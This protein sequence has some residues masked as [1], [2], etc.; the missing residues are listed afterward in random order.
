MQPQKVLMSRDGSDA[1]HRAMHAVPAFLPVEPHVGD[2][3]HIWTDNGEMVTSAV[4]R[5]A[6]SEREIVVE[7]RN[8]RYRLQLST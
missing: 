3:L 8:S 5:V 7:T 4:R 6:K 1:F 2:P